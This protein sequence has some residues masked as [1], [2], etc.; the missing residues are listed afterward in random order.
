MVLR[1]RNHPSVVMWSIGNEVIEQWYP[2]GWKIAA[3]LAGIVREEDRTRPVTSAF[4]GEMAG[5]SGFQT[6]LDVMGYNYKPREYAKLHRSNP[7]LPIIGSETASTISSRGEYFFPVSDDKLQGRVD[8]QVSSYDLSANV[9]SNIPDA[10]FQG[11]DECPSVA[12][13]FVWTGFDYLGEPTPYNSDSSNLLNFSDPE[14]RRLAEQQLEELGQIPVPSRSSYFG[15][16]DLAGF[17]KDRYYIYQARWRPH[18]RMAHI[19]PHWNWPE[20][21]AQITPVH[22]YSSADEAEL[23]LNGKSLGRRKR[24]RAQYRFRWDE[25]VYQP[26]ELKVITYRKGKKWATALRRT[27]GAAASVA[28]SVD[29]NRL[30]ADGR[31]LAFVTVSIVDEHEAVVPRSHHLVEFTLEGP[32]QILALD[33][34]DPTSFEPFQGSKRHVFNGLALVVIRSLAGRT[35]KITLAASSEGL[36]GASVTLLSR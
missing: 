29:R 22:V 31:D 21:V 6:A 11:L 30:Q 10:E 32:G 3:R 27:T 36:R 19:L 34:G 14:Q 12:G 35:G 2:D 20:R 5:Y 13:E 9:W 7:T 1:D 25:V 28:L 33:N 16:V 18:L 24:K 15:I 23:F 8:F 26:G 4:N 17:P